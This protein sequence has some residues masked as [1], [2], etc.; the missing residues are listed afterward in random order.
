[1]VERRDHAL[2]VNWGQTGPGVS[3]AMASADEVPDDWQLICGLKKGDAQCALA[4]VDRYR[5]AI[6]EIAL[7]HIERGAG[8]DELEER[9]LVGLL[10]AVYLYDPAIHADGFTP[11]AEASMGRQMAAANAETGRVSL[12]NEQDLLNR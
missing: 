10:D 6:Q 9:G 1:M 3:D 7:R 5:P 8:W 2:C 4:L 11:V 12:G